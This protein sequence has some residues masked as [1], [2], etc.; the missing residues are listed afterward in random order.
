MIHYSIRVSSAAKLYRDAT[1][2][3]FRRSDANRTRF[4]ALRELYRSFTEQNGPEAPFAAS[5]AGL[6]IS[7]AARAIRC[8]QLF[9][10]HG[11]SH[12]QTISSSIWY[13]EQC[14]RTGRIRAARDRLVF[15]C[16][17]SSGGWRCDAR[18]EDR[19]RNRRS[20]GARACPP[21][22]SE[23]AISAPSS[24]AC[25]LGRPWAGSPTGGRRPVAA[26]APT[27]ETMTTSRLHPASALSRIGARTFVR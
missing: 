6:V 25:L 5:A 20:R 7:R 8:Q 17:T 24:A 9:R 3:P 26:N 16:R 23:T 1:M 21:V 14:C 27:R 13:P 15:R 11:F 4:R 18:P 2:F 10:S 22:F 12:R 19:A